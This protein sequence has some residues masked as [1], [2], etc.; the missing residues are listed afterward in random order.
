MAGGAH[1][2]RRSVFRRAAPDA[3]RG[4][5][6][7]GAGPAPGGRAARGRDARDAGGAAARGDGRLRA[8]A[9]RGEWAAGRLRPHDPG[10]SG[11]GRAAHGA[12]HARRR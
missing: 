9:H 4:A 7:A 11:V 3:S 6:P 10:G 1:E 8:R 12:R 2:H 5:G